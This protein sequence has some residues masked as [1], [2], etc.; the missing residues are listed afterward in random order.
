MKLFTTRVL[1]TLVS[2]RSL[3]IVIISR[4]KKIEVKKKEYTYLKSVFYL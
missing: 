1:I 2:K 3:K 4:H